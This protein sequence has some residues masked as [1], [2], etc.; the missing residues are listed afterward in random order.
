MTWRKRLPGV[1]LI[2][3]ALLLVL[4]PGTGLGDDPSEAPPASPVI[5]GGIPSHRVI[6][7]PPGYIANAVAY[8]SRSR[9]TTDEVRVEVCVTRDGGVDTY[10]Y[11][12]TNL[13]YAVCDE[14][15]R[16]M[17]IGSVSAPDRLDL[18]SIAA[19]G[20]PG[21]TH[22]DGAACHWW[23][24][25]P[26]DAGIEIGESAIFTVS[27][28]GPTGIGTGRVNVLHDT[29]VALDA[30]SRDDPVVVMESLGPVAALP[31]TPPLSGCPEGHV[32][33]DVGYGTPPTLPSPGFGEVRVEECV[34]REGGV[35]TYTYTVTNLSYYLHPWGIALRMPLGIAVFR[36]PNPARLEPV[37]VT[38]PPNW[39]FD[40]HARDSWYWHAVE[41]ERGEVPGSL[42]L[43]ESAVFSFSVEGPTVDGPLEARAQPRASMLPEL[44]RDDTDFVVT[45]PS[46]GPHRL[47]LGAVP[48]V[49]GDEVPPL[50][51][52]PEGHVAYDVAYGTASS[53]GEVRVEECVTRAGDVDTYT[54][55]VTNLS[56][57]YSHEGERY[58][59]GA[60]RVPRSAGI[61]PLSVTIPT[62]WDFDSVAAD[63]W[64]WSLP[65]GSIGIW[66]GDSAVFSFTVAGPTVD[67]PLEVL[68]L[69]QFPRPPVP[70]FYLE[71]FVVNVLSTGP[72]PAGDPLPGMGVL[73]S[74]EPPGQLPPPEEPPDLMIESLDATC[75]CEWNQQ[76]EYWCE[77][78]VQL[79]VRNQGESD[80]GRFTVHLASDEGSTE[81]M[82]F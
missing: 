17:G 82:V 7:C 26:G 46:T 18:G 51:G 64:H 14:M 20:P 47:D 35:D 54:Y 44:L 81:R 15:G 28:A 19:T 4:A 63:E 55:T 69:P 53:F 29:A 37:S 13:G 32:A 52:C 61:V 42:W 22:R 36:V 59:V 75:I 27:Y 67:G 21:W 34:T 60:F 30:A 79:V 76:Q 41:D 58:G 10:A 11:V 24:L 73:P 39:R 12:I 74:A 25:P 66:P 33:Y 80:A 70:T 45:V 77:L 72:Q 2:G 38:T 56:Y 40:R 31:G 43:G 68:A 9:A 57:V 16:E 62:G 3:C 23:D 78:S 49:T 50:A 48:G 6:S 71:D 5:P 1:A 65:S 8:G